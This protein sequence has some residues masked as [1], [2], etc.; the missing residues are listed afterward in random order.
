MDI[1]HIHEIQLGG[2]D[3]IGNL[4]ILNRSTNRSIGAQIRHQLDKLPE[5]AKIDKIEITKPA[6]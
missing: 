5:G 3:K 6:K 2:P 1:D 4:Q